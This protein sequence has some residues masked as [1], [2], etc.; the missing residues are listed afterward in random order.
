MDILQPGQ[1]DVPYTVDQAGWHM[2]NALTS[3]FNT[4]GGSEEAAGGSFE[5]E[6]ALI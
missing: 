2:F 1:D 6:R 5:V 3:A 4:F